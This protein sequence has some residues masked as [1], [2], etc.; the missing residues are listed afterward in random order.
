MFDSVGASYTTD[1]AKTMSTTPRRGCHPLLWEDSPTAEDCGDLEPTMIFGYGALFQT[2]TTCTSGLPPAGCRPLVCEIDDDCPRWET[3]W[4]GEPIVRE[5]AC[6]SGLCQNVDI[7]LVTDGTIRRS[8][9]KELCNATLERGEVNDAAFES[10][11]PSDQPSPD[12][13]CPLPLPDVC[14]QP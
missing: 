11:C 1:P 13:R 12:D 6:R 10:Y 4:E 14:L 9:A 5:Y 7:D 8:E 3:T 2:C